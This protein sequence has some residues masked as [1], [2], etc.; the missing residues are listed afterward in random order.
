MSEN[1][2]LA[3]IEVCRRRSGHYVREFHF[4]AYLLIDSK[5]LHKTLYHRIR[6]HLICTLVCFDLRLVR[7]ALCAQLLFDFRLSFGEFCSLALRVLLSADRS[8]DGDSWVT[9]RAVAARC[10]IWLENSISAPAVRGWCS[11][12]RIG[13]RIEGAGFE[14]AFGLFCDTFWHSLTFWYQNQYYNP[15]LCDK[16]IF[17]F[18]LHAKAS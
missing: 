15:R 17:L 8:V 1:T 16:K 11:G 12:R 3:A 4:C 6:D 9:S 18:F 7:P 10:R 5:F 14:A 13:S 2:S